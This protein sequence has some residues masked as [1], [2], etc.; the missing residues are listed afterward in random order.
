M[1][2]NLQREQIDTIRP[3]FTSNS[4][5]DEAV[6]SKTTGKSVG[7]SE[8]KDLPSIAAALANK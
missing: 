8:T 7:N 4:N 5:G 2:V 3:S 1:Y 6:E